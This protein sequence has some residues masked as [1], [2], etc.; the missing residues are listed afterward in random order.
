MSLNRR[1]NNMRIFGKNRFFFQSE[2][3]T[4]AYPATKTIE[5]DKQLICTRCVY[6]DKAANEY[7]V[8]DYYCVYDSLPATVYIL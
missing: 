6:V 1:Q 4:N 7:D 5:E 2:A 3:H 8:Y